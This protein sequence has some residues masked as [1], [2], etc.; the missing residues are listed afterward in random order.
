[1]APSS[2]QRT[3]APEASGCVPYVAKRKTLPPELIDKI[4]GFLP[5]SLAD[6]QHPPPEKPRW[7][8]VRHLPLPRRR[9]RDRHRN[10]EEPDSDS[11]ISDPDAD[12][13]YD[14]LD[15]NTER[16]WS[17]EQHSSD[18]PL[19][20]HAK[21]YVRPA[22]A[23]VSKAFQ[24]AV[25]RRTFRNLRLL[26]RDFLILG[27][28]TRENPHRREFIKQ[29]VYVVHVLGSDGRTY[30]NIDDCKRNNKLVGAAVWRLMRYLA[31]PSSPCSV[32]LT[33]LITT[34]VCEAW[35][36]PD[37]PR[38]YD[39]QE[40]P[41]D[42]RSDAYGFSYARPCANEWDALSPVS[43]VKSIEFETDIHERQVHPAAIL[44]LTKL[45]RQLE[46]ATFA[47]Y[48]PYHLDKFRRDMGYEFLESLQAFN[49]GSTAR[50]ANIYIMSPH[51]VPDTRL[52]EFT[53]D[54]VDL[55]LAE[56]HRVVR[57]LSKF[58]YH[59]RLHHSFF[60]PSPEPHL[61][62][63]WH[64]MTHLDITFDLASPEGVWYLKP[65]R[66]YVFFELCA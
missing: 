31:S 66:D 21:S 20:H 56:L 16:R 3:R 30:E 28:M 17:E 26:C 55:L 1:M 51:Y 10:I 53:V 54:G 52:K 22:I 14:G 62:F 59:G 60:M 58:H 2:S 46:S 48:E 27:S 35:G 13:D 18:T 11:E 37:Q 39:N 44:Q 42:P 63:P 23:T 29:I 36:S 15:D 38:D 49:F 40:Q 7:H 25:E 43:C 61:V 45:F 50:E 41:I 65:P 32:A 12:S 64:F 47:Y 9:H 8:I 6:E 34:P 19:A 57:N 4:V 5:V 24:M 33:I